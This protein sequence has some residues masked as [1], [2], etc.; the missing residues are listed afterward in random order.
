MPP[1]PALQREGGRLQLCH[2]RLGDDRAGGPL[3]GRQEP[4]ELQV[5]HAFSKLILSHKAQS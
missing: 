4:Q 3:Q 5:I 2:V 1:E